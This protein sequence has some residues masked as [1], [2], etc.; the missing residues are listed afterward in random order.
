MRICIKLLVHAS[1]ALACPHSYETSNIQTP[2]RYEYNTH[3]DEK[4]WHERYINISI[5]HLSAAL[6]LTVIKNC[7]IPDSQEQ[8]VMINALCKSHILPASNIC[9]NQNMLH[10]KGMFF[11]WNEQIILVHFSPSWCL[12]LHFSEEIVN[13]RHNGRIN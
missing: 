2:R 13:L 4:Y 5:G 12:A 1:E 8:S 7:Q 11:E 9:S 3:T 10:R 6:F